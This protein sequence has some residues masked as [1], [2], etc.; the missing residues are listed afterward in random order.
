MTDIEKD[1]KDDAEEMKA[2]ILGM[3]KTMFWSIIAVLIL[4]LCVAVYYNRARLGL[5][6]GVRG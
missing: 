4:L 6:A 5:T 2:K 3:S 1:M